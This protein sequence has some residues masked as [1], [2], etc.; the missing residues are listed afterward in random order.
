[1]KKKDVEGSEN[2]YYCTN[3]PETCADPN[4]TIHN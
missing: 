1:M 4:C 2:T 3:H